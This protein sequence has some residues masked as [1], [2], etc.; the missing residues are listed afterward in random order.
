M[1][2]ETDAITASFK[3][4]SKAKDKMAALKKKRAKGKST[5]SAPETLIGN[6]Y[7]SSDGEYSDEDDYEKIVD[8][9]AVSLDTDDDDEGEELDEEKD[10][11]E[12]DAFMNFFCANFLMALHPNAIDELKKINY[13]DADTIEKGLVAIKVK[14]DSI[15]AK[16]EEM[17]RSEKLNSFIKIARSSIG[18]EITKATKAF[19]NSDTEEA[20]CFISEKTVPLEKL[21]VIRLEE[22]ELKKQSDPKPVLTGARNPTGKEI[23]IKNGLSKMLQSIFALIHIDDRIQALAYRWAYEEGI[24]EDVDIT[25]V[26]ASFKIYEQHHMND[27]HSMFDALIEYIEKI[28]NKGNQG[29]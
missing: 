3:S 22:D 20:E 5:K 13:E 14:I 25:N 6:S 9:S 23:I 27:M 18:M 19:E 4:I 2:E 7:T 15:I 29:R 8:R 11:A 16:V 26:F 1:K 21:R 17:Y 28:M 12:M 10:D 24:E